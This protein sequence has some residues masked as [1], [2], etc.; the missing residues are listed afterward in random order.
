L[1]DPAKRGGACP[2]CHLSHSSS[3]A[4]RAAHRGFGWFTSADFHPN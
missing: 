2:R 1:A 4:Q 3:S